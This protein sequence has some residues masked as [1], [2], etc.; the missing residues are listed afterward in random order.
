MTNFASRF[1]IAIQN[2]LTTNHLKRFRV[3]DNGGWPVAELEFTNGTRFVFRNTNIAGYYAP[4]EFWNN[5]KRKALVSDFAGSWRMTDKEMI[6]MARSTLA[7][8]GYGKDFVQT[9]NTPELIKPKGEFAK[10]IP[11]C[12][13]QWMYPSPQT[14]TQW[15]YVEIDADKKQVKAIYFDDQSFWGNN[16]VVDVPITKD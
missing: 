5:D 8:L 1:G 14:M 10:R 13:V 6:G 2:P 7:R 3:D 11:R 16:P 15:S 12:L 9:G 4:D